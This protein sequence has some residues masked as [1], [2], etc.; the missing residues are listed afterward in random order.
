MPHQ[1]AVRAGISIREYLLLEPRHERRDRPHLH[2]PGLAGPAAC[3][4]GSRGGQAATPPGTGPAATSPP[5]ENLEAEAR[6][7]VRNISFSGIHAVVSKPVPLPDAE[8]TSN[9]NLGEVYSCIGLS[10]VGDVFLENI[11]LSDVH[12]IFP[13][14]GTAEQAALRDVPKVVG[15]YYAAGVFPAYALYARNVRGLT[16]NIVRFELSAP[17]LRPAVV[18]DHVVDAAVN[19]LCIEGNRDA[20]SALRFIDSQDILLSAARL[21]KPASVF[22]QVEG[23]DN[24]NIAIDGGDLSKAEKPLAFTNGGLEK[25][26]KLRT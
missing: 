18:L 6:G 20:E 7:V 13:G 22:L 14:G 1:D 15:E 4:G 8:F 5:A 25:S 12:V 19:G 23:A 17:D 3:W 26:V 2:Q 24:R 16:L 21:L 11:S 9:Y 10:A